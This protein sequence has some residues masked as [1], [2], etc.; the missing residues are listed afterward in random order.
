MKR[1]FI[2]FLLL[3]FGAIGVAFPTTATAQSASPSPTPEASADTFE[4]VK[5]YL[6]TSSATDFYENQPPLPAQFR[7]VRI[8]HVG[9]T[10]KDFS[11]RL[12]GEFL[13]ADEKAEWTGFVT[14]KTSK[15]EQ[16]IGSATTYCTDPKMIWD[17]TDDLSTPLKSRLDALKKQKQP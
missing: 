13:T 15:Y 11:Y 17:T 16:F 10:K 14:I 1:T 2:V 5:E 8:G 12:C 9:E 7:N 3:A 4:V 6:I